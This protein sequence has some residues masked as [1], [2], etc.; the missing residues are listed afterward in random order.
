MMKR[1]ALYDVLPLDPTAWPVL[2]AAHREELRNTMAAQAVANKV[3]LSAMQA[4][5]AQV[6]PSSQSLRPVLAAAFGFRLWSCTS[7]YQRH[8]MPSQ[9]QTQCRRSALT[10][11]SSSGLAPGQ[12]SWST[13]P[14]THAPKVP[15]RVSSLYRPCAQE[16]GACRTR[17]CAAHSRCT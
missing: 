12:L 17:R 5:G 10:A 1:R 11:S 3:D 16:T 2:L 4:P 13:L 7:R 6:T 9:A 8:H 15:S 14:Y